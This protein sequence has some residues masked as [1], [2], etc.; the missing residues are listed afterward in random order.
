MELI[1]SFTAG[2]DKALNSSFS[3]SEVMYQAFIFFSQ[4]LAIRFSFVLDVARIVGNF[5]VYFLRFIP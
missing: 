1:M 5:W 2:L 4:K 3:I